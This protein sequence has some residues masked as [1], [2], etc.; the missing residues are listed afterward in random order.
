M[1]EQG[2]PPGLYGRVL[3][4][5]NYWFVQTS[6]VHKFLDVLVLFVAVFLGGALW[7]G[8]Q[9][10]DALLAFVGH[11]LREYPSLNMD[12]VDREW[13]QL[14]RIAKKSGAT[15]V[16]LYSIDM[17]RNTRTLVKIQSDDE[18]AIAL[19]GPIGQT[20]SFLTPGLNQEHLAGAAALITGDYFIGGRMSNPNTIALFIPIPDH[21]GQLLCGVLVVNY[22]K[23]MSRDAVAASRVSMLAFVND[24]V[25]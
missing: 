1:S 9:R 21:P 18:S 2:Q 23:E 4:Y 11:A 5:F 7:I 6:P 24:V 22:P 19:Y 20:T 15:C 8:Y 3:D 12:T 10:T 17:A 13:D 25:D 14:V 16:E